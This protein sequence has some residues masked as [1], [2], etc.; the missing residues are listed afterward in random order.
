MKC[1]HCQVAIH[2]SYGI[3]QIAAV[4]NVVRDGVT[5]APQIVWT[6]GHQRCPECYGSIIVLN[7]HAARQNTPE[8]FL[9][10]PKGSSRPLPPP[11]VIDP[12]RQDYIESCAVL[13]DSEKASAALSRR[14]LQILLRDKGGVKDSDLYNEIEEFIASGKAPSDIEESLHAVRQIGNF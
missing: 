2:K 7:R 4:D 6:T 3:T 5:I 14:C 12:Y 13:P 8:E 1:P 9:V 11:E 10:Y